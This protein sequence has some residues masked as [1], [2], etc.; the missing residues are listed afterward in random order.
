MDLL[1]TNP[2]SEVTPI[3]VVPPPISTT[4]YPEGS[5]TG[6]PAPIAAGR[7]SSTR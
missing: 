6:I 1:S 2:P 7:G 4:I 3:S 5:L